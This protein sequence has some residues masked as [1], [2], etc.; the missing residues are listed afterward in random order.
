MRARAGRARAPG[1]CMQF[2]AK[3]G[4]LLALAGDQAPEASLADRCGP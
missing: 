2:N 1:V 4:E 3:Q